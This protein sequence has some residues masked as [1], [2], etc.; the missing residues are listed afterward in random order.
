MIDIKN[1]TVK[2]GVKTVYNK[3]I[4]G[5]DAVTFPLKTLAY[6]SLSASII[7]KMIISAFDTL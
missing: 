1:L 7:S 2:Y 5:R 6:L 3:N 4:K